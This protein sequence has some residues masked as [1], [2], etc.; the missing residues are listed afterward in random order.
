MNIS[1]LMQLLTKGNRKFRRLRSLQQIE[2]IQT[3]RQCEKLHI[4]NNYIFACEN[5]EKLTAAPCN[6]LGVQLQRIH[7]EEAQEVRRQLDIVFPHLALCRVPPRHKLTRCFTTL[8]L[9]VESQTG[10]HS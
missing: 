1:K 9:Q 7:H 3:N 5:N 2:S 4:L 8:S 10:T 6:L